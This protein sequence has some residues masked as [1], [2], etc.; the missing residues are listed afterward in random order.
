MEEAEWSVAAEQRR[1]YRVKKKRQRRK[2]R[3]ECLP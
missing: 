1:E 2:M 3:W